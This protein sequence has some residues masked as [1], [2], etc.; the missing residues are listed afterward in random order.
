[1]LVSLE[2]LNFAFMLLCLLERS[3]CA[4]VAALAGLSILLAR[5][6]AKLPGFEFAN[7]GGRDASRVRAVSPN[8]FDVE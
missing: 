2:V 5:I 6:Q 4:K 3:E 8:L 7:H 1:M